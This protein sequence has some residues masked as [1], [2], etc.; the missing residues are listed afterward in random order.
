[1][2]DFTL[3]IAYVATGSIIIILL[4]VAVFIIVSTPMEKGKD[5]R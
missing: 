3:G 4:A 2:N 1:M 5:I